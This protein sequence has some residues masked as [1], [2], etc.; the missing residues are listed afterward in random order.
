[1]P[2]S[3]QEF[4]FLAQI[5]HVLLGIIIPTL[6]FTITTLL[7][8][9]DSNVYLYLTGLLVVYSAVKEYYFDQKYEDP[10]VRGSNTQD[11]L[12]QAGTGIIIACAIYA[13]KLW[14]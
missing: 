13:C 11:F 7:H 6:T 2:V 5:N 9:P 10:D 14:I 8:S 3:N 4:N 1:M 12:M